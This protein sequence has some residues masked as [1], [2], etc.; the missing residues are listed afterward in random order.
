[1]QLMHVCNAVWTCW[2]V[3]AHSWATTDVAVH[4][5]DCNRLGVDGGGLTPRVVRLVSQCDLG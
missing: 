2:T 5:V 1:M 3:V 4:S